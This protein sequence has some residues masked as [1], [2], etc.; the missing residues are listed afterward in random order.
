MGRLA[1]IAAIAGVA[2]CYFEGTVAYHP[3][4]SQ[5]VAG[6][7]GTATG[8]GWSAGVNIG[9]YIDVQIPS[10]TLRGIAAGVSPDALNGYGIAPSDPVAKAAAKSF[11]VRADVTIPT[12]F[13][14]P[15]HQA[16]TIGYHWL[17]NLSTTIAP[18]TAEAMTEEASGRMWFLGASMA[19]R[20]LVRQ[21]AKVDKFIAVLSL[22]VE[23][24]RADIATA[25]QG[26]VTV[27]STG[28][29]ARLLIA[30][31]MVGSPPKSRS[32]TDPLPSSPPKSNAG[33]HYVDD[34]DTG[35]PSWKCE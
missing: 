13:A 35:K 31:A 22:G 25:N 1:L 27:A 14:A 5:S 4:I 10:H 16:V 15:L 29:G 6:R 12:T 21:N 30:P 11:A 2:G 3:R 26:D 28:I 7:D 19:Y 32:E 20:V 23:R 34:P 33:C 8:P 18:D 17:S 24:M 9:I